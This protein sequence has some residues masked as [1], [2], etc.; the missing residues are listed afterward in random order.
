MPLEDQV[1]EDPLLLLLEED[2]VEEV[3][4]IELSEISPVA[5]RRKKYVIEDSDSVRIHSE[6]F[7][8]PLQQVAKLTLTYSKSFIHYILPNKYIQIFFFSLTI[9]SIFGQIGMDYNVVLRPY[10]LAPG[11]CV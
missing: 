5:K 11:T 10:S 6:I 7:K 1:Q 2:A 4:K 8:R 3:D 9:I